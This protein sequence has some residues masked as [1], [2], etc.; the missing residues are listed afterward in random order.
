MAPPVP[1]PPHS[2]A[3]IDSPELI[4]GILAVGVFVAWSVAQAGAFTTASNPGGLFILGLLVGTGIACRRLLREM[5]RPLLLALAFLGAFVV[6]SFGSIAWA[7][8][9]GD[10]WDGANRALLYFTTFALFAVPPWRPG[11]AAIVLGLFALAMATIGAVTVLSAAGSA[12]PELYFVA[13]SFA[14]PTGY[15]NADAA[16]FVLAFFPALFGASRR[17]TPWPLRGLL[18]ASAGLLGELALLPQSRGAVIVFPIAA[19]LYLAVVPGRVRTLVA[20]LPVAAAVAATATPVLDVFPALGN[21]DVGPALDRAWHA[22]AVSFG[23][24][25]A[26]G[27]ALGLAERRLQVSDRATSLVSR[28][29][30]AAAA[31]AALVA[32]VVVIAAIGNPVSWA[33]DRWHNFKDGYPEQGFSSSR[34]GGSLGSN[35]YDFWRVAADEF[36]DTPLHGEG[37]GN[38]VVGY[39][40]HRRSGEEPTDPHSLPLATLSQTGLVGAALFTAFLLFATGGAA[41]V[42]W[43]TGSELGAAL[44]AACVIVFAYWLLHSSGDWFWLLPAL[45]APAFAFLALAARIDAPRSPA[46]GRLDSFGRVRISQRSRWPARSAAAVGAV[47]AVFAAAS[48]ALPWT[49]AKE[50]QLAASS[51]GAHPHNAFDR[52]DRAR[53][54]N[55]LS[56]QPDLVAGAIAARL[57]Q[58]RRMRQSFTDALDRDPNNWYALLELGALDSLEGHRAAAV[59]RLRSASRLNPRDPLIRSVLRSVERG[60]A[61]PL[62]SL[63]RRLLSRVCQRVGR[64]HETRFCK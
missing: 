32:V 2:R 30:G 21:G 59:S 61:V 57:G 6:W 46:A 47:V 45:S 42:R 23:A 64:T 48:Y 12:Q 7:D 62:R 60:K 28:G 40:Q 33:S 8:V 52:L 34:L 25:L 36:V 19:L 26:V 16:L 35:R 44:A 63:D 18:L 51:W 56:A 49:A 50:T 38:F 29:V 17:E 27:F 15:H 55:F 13:G 54:L 37:S 24:L 10:A 22:M 1:G 5:P 20:A 3:L 9:Q 4:P 41:R 31:I 14:E 39:L 11:S 43:R 58:R 53:K